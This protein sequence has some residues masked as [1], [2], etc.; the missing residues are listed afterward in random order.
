MG[1]IGIVAFMIRASLAFLVLLVLA[2]GLSLGVPTA[3]AQDIDAT[4]TPTPTMTPTPVYEYSF[5][6]SSGS[7]VKVERTITYG[8]IAVVTVGLAMLAS[9][10]IYMFLR[11]PKLWR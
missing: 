2:A 3:Q 10:F 9:F 7:Q 8:D 11:I 4:L 1:F 6:L 5:S